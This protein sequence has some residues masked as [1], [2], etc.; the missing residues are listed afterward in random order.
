MLTRVEFSLFF[1]DIASD[2]IENLHLIE[3]FIYIVHRLGIL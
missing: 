2:C 3:I 1:S